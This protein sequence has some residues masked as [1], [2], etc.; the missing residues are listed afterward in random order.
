MDHPL[1]RSALAARLDDLGVDGVLVTALPNVRYLTGFT[2]SNAAALVARD[3]AVF[4]TDGR[5]I[6]QSRHEVPDVDRVVAREGLE[7]EIASHASRLGVARLGFEAAATTVARHRR[8]AEALDDVELVA[9][10]DAVEH[11]R[12]AKD[13][14]ELE[15]L[16]SAQ[17]VTDE[18]FE[19]ILDA[20]E[21]GM[22][23][24]QLAALLE[25]ALRR[26]GAHGLAFDP[27]VAFGECAAEPHHAPG[28]RLLEE[29]D[30]VK[31]DF[32]ARWDGYHADMTRTI[33]FG[34]PASELR[35]IHDVVR[36]AQQ[37]G[38]DAARA[39]VTTGE[40]DAAARRVIAD[41]GYGDRFTHGLG[42]GVGLEIHEAPWLKPNGTDEL[43]VG[44][45][46]TIE[47][48][49]YVPGLGGVRVEDMIEVTDEGCRVLG[50]STR[51]LIEL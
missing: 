28:H 5:Y 44:A 13:P 36:E 49:V 25:A 42:H 6:E 9:L 32:G 38:I 4:F 21:V 24:Q 43:P 30:V 22:S 17:A 26:D 15:A 20:I 45:V 1:R 33:A 40:I 39:G 50:S 14:E 37:A 23:E 19:E 3:G 34:S 51:E 16:R 2:G 8:I 29:G 12:R 48:G 47:P 35:K 10:D 11:H 27:I 31:L 41:A 46:V 7:R 18:A